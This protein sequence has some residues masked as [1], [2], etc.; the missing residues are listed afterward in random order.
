MFA[1]TIAS[2][3]QKWNVAIGNSWRPIKQIPSGNDNKKNK[4]IEDFSM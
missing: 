1:R 2:S 4:Y 3:I